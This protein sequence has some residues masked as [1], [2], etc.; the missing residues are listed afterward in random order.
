MSRYL[1][2]ALLALV[3]GC[4]NLT[5]P[6]IIFSE[7]GP[8]AMDP[9]SAVHDATPGRDRPLEPPPPD[10]PV[11]DTL[12]SDLP[13]PDGRPPDLVAPDGPGPDTRPPDG[14]LLANGV[15]CVAGD[16]CQSGVC[17]EGVCCDQ[18]CL[19]LCRSC[20]IF[21]T[22]GT[23]TIA[24]VGADP[25]SECPAQTAATCGRYGGCDGAGACRLQPVGTTCAPS[26]CTG[27]TETGASGCDGRGTC[28]PASA[29]SCAPFVC[30][31]SACA[32]SCTGGAQCTAGNVCFIDACVAAGTTPALY[33]SF[34]ETSGSTALDGS[35]NGLEGQYTGNSS[36]PQPSTE[37][38]TLMF[39]D[40][41]SRS[42]A[43][44]ARQGVRLATLPAA[45]RPANSFTISVWYRATRV[46]QDNAD[47]GSD[48]VS[49]GDQYMLR[50]FPTGAQFVKRTSG[51]FERCLGTVGNSLDGQ[52]HHVAASTST[53]GMKVYFDGQERCSN[54]LDGNVDYIAGDELWVGRH[55]D[56]DTD[57]DFDGHIDEVRIYTRVLSATEIQ[58]LASGRR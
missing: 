14:A 39:P 42:F 13:I 44:S 15:G 17:S 36:S 25:R 46:D 53:S 10:G 47:P 52:W 31:A 48:L 32:T 29:R 35:G 38:P 21:G 12:L 45:L 7:D 9:D 55:G 8:T 18:A 41:R 37:V 49:A 28:L 30:G 1:R 26:R 22:V 27:S 5:P 19:Q 23:C 16:A 54:G 3:A 33:W 40:P 2:L 58:N 56:G 50:L 34:D 20:K 43:I 57:R 11:A 6:T 51:G 24:P 4:V